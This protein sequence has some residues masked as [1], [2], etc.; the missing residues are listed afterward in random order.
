MAR[1]ALDRE[2]RRQQL[3]EAAVRV[4]ARKGYRETSIDDI[5][6]EAEVARGTF[7]LYFPGKKEIFLAIIDH[8]FELVSELVDRLMGEE[9]P[10]RLDRARFR[11]HVLTW[12][13]FFMEH[14]DLTKVIY[15]EATSI[16]PQFEDRWNRLSETVKHFLIERV[17]ALQR[18]GHL[19]Q[20]LDPHAWAL[21]MEGVFHAAICH[22]ILQL[23]Q[24][25]LEWLADQWVDLMF[26]GIAPRG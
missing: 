8:Y 22:Y 4:F 19:R 2:T 24:P 10:A 14:R 18:R 11:E 13:R 6:T 7:Y 9:W 3:L 20:T 12:L 21:F 15:R 16:D 5:I 17:R 23:D 25:D 1:I 26:W